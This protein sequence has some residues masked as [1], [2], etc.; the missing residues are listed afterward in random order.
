MANR[1]VTIATYASCTEAHLARN[2]LRAEGIDSFVADE[3]MVSLGYGTTALYG[4]VKL[5]V[6]EYA[7]PR[8]AEVLAQVS[9]AFAESDWAE[10][11][12]R[13]QDELPSSA[14]TAVAEPALL[15]APDGRGEPLDRRLPAA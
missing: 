6:M 7:A 2:L 5:Q 1:L 12:F 9:D 10:G 11:A 8:A 13:V 14:K 4:G 15:R 3:N